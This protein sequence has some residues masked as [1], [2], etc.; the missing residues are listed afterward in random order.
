MGLQ[1][2]VLL[3]FWLLWIDLS[4]RLVGSENS[5]N[6]IRVRVAG[7]VRV[8]LNV[9]R[10]QSGSEKVFKALLYNRRQRRDLYYI[11]TLSV[12]IM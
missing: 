10:A 11:N 2:R 4:H 5:L 9:H 7:K 8:F 6:R 1:G 3:C 12:F